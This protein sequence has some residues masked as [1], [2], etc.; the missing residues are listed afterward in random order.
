MDYCDNCQ[1]CAS[2]ARSFQRVR[3]TIALGVSDCPLKGA[4]STRACTGSSDDRLGEDLPLQHSAPCT[5]N[6]AG[7]PIG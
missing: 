1:T 4:L 7:L 3:D 2:S 5:A 6:E